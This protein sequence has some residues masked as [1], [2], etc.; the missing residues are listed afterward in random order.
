[1]LLN[2]YTHVVL[3]TE[4]MAKIIV[5]SNQKGGVGK[6]TTAV[7]LASC[8]AS[9]EKKKVLMIDLDPQGNASSGL[10][11][12][13]TKYNIYHVLTNDIPIKKAIVK[14]SI[15]R[16]YIVPSD[17]N[18]AGAELE[19]ASVVGREVILK[20][21]LESVMKDY[22]FIVIDTPPTLGILTVNSLTAAHSV[23]IPLQCEYYAMEGLTQ[24]LNTIKLI[25]KR[26]NPKLKLEGILLTMFDQRNKLS[27]L[28]SKEIRSHFGEVYGFHI[29]RNVKLSEASSHG[30][31]I[32][33]YAKKSAGALAYMKFAK[34]VSYKN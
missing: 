6:T 7:N 5:V 19:L 18:L 17:Q 2:E 27:H 26:L 14:S 23:I 29:P 34:E 22:D 21:A 12:V 20:E 8:L 3:G 31:P 33:S 30:K 1:M 11:V 25:K 4:N 28:I 15:E 9:E 16:L 32:V 13:P 10:G 24:I